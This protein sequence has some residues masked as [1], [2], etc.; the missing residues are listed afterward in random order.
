MTTKEQIEWFVVDLV[1]G[2]LLASTTQGFLI[3]FE[4]ILAIGLIL[5]NITRIID[6]FKTKNGKAAIAW[7]KKLFRK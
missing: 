3:F 5:Y 2:V 1:G 6:W 7:F 4:I